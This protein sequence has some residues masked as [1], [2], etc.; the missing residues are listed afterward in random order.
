MSRILFALTPV[1]GHVRP[2][3]PLAR[4][5]VDE[6][7]DVVVYTGHKFAHAI[8]ATGAK[9]A[10]IVQGRDLDDADLDA[11]SLEHGAPAPGI[12]RVQWD[13]LHHFV[14]TVP[15]FL[16][17]IDSLVAAERPDVIVMDNG[18]MAGAIAARRHDLPSVLFSV[19][20]LAIS[21]K[22]TAPF[23][24]GLQ[25]PRTGLDGLRYS[26]LDWFT[27]KVVFRDV[28][29]AAE[30]IVADAGQPVPDGFFLDWAQTE[31]TR[32]LH[33]SVPSF[34]YPR[35]DLPEHVELVGPYLPAGIDRFEP[36]A[37]WDDVLEARATG[38]PVVVVT[39]GTVATDPE[40]LLWP[41]IEG[42]A[43]EDVL[44]VATTDA[45]DSYPANV[46]AA[47]FVPFDRLL[48]LV[49][50]LVTNGGFGGVQQALAAGV[51]VVVAGRTEDKAEVGARVV[52][53]GVGLALP[54]DKVTDGTT[55]QAVRDG[56]SRVLDNPSFAR[57]AAVLA[58]EYAEYDG[59]A[60]TVSVVTEVAGSGR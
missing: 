58:Q 12:K 17:D 50:V 56:V 33:T 36:P 41:A 59:I 29:K 25:P 14:A 60:R 30:R 26:V 23:G 48:P 8:T 2:A 6:G 55:S 45:L 13:V 20:P 57:R 16:A 28:Q 19:S 1:T 3:L 11:W 44:V 7:H 18:F 51:P 42:L 54:T 27:R 46:R 5:L 47:P 37:W 31:V 15:G 52:W 9:H 34:E 10:P 35:S 32:V 24:M 53:S 43:D 39:Q 21:S 38:V 22:D 4:A 40:R 49:D